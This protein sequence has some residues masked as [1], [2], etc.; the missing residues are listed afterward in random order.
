MFSTTGGVLGGMFTAPVSW[1]M[2]AGPH[3]IFDKSALQS[4]SL[5]ET[6]W[7]DQFFGTVITPLFFAEVLADLEKEV[8]RGKTPEQVVGALALKTPDMQSTACV[9]HHRLASGVLY[10]EDLPL[11]GRIPRGQGQVVE[12]NGLQGIFYSKSPEEDALDRWYNGEFLDVERQFAKNWRKNLCNV[13]HDKEYAFFQKWF[14]MGK[15]KTLAEAKA[16]ADAYIDGSPQDGAMRFGLKMVGVPDDAQVDIM[17]RWRTKNSPPIRNFAPYFRH[18]FG[19]D[20]FCSLA[21]SADLISRVRPK[22][23]ADNKVDLAYL[24]YLPFC[25]VFVSADNLHKR[26]VPH[27]LRPD[28][29]F[30]DAADL[31]ADLAKLDALYSAL[32][33]EEKKTGFY[34]IAKHPPLDDDYLVSRLWDKRG[35]EWREIAS[36][37]D[38]LDPE[39]DK[40]IIAEL[41]KISDAAKAGNP[42]AR[43]SLK[44]A[45]FMTINRSILRR[46]GKWQRVPD[47]V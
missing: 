24:Y 31:K 35:P 46:K 39:R 36:K 44:E 21:I 34:K 2:P 42:N 12:L 8:G 16:M 7:L 40:D 32:P 6:N 45:S 11:D 15:P 10:G 17:Q 27:F 29:S 26:V 22:G 43:L 23:K 38:P 18:L 47:D 13:N 28:Q 41:K 5:D 9:H 3:L 19:V 1:D 33:E 20:L 30:V 14:L 37:P 25:H 4:F